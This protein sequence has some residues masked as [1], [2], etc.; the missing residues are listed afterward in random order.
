MKRTLIVLVLFIFSLTSIANADFGTFSIPSP[1]GAMYLGDGYNSLQDN[2]VYDNNCLEFPNGAIETTDGV[3][4]MSYYC[5]VNSKK[6]LEDNFKNNFSGS[7]D[8]TLPTFTAK[9]SL[10]KEIVNETK[11]ISDKITIIAFWRQEDKKVYSNGLPQIK[12]DVIDL[13]QSNPL[14]F[15]KLYGDK[16]VSGVTL[17][18]MFYIVY[19]AD[20]SNVAT[21][22]KSTVK[23]A[24]ELSF[25]KILGANL[26]SSQESFVSEKLSNVTIISR[27][28]AYGINNLTGVYSPSDF[29]NLVSRVSGSQSAVITKELKDFSYTTNYP[30]YSENFSEY[31]NMAREW[32]K[33]YHLL[34]Y[35]QTNPRISS[36]LR[37]DCNLSMIDI[38][39][40]LTHI[41]SQDETS[42]YPIGELSV[43][44][45][46]YNR[47]LTEMNI[48]QRW[49]NMPEV[50]MINNNVNIISKDF[51]FSSIGDIEVL[52]IQADCVC[53]LPFRLKISLYINKD[54]NLADFCETVVTNTS[55]VNLYEGVKFHDKF[56]IRYN[57][58]I[59][60]ND[61]GV[62]PPILIIK[63]S[64]KER[65]TDLIWL[66]VNGY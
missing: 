19:Q 37:T 60:V 53:K 28:Y 39:N 5:F 9:S 65:I 54:G 23:R 6:E 66:H 16:Y 35:I 36:G 57:S 34:E 63:C 58:N 33:H 20:T 27:T 25:N 45:Y 17:G 4:S 47:Y 21:S 26:S 7:G 24:V 64:Y 44:N 8:L 55:I 10:T 22:S 41:Y 38:T 56:T 42:R 61:F 46:L 62:T 2:Y 3:S 14:Q 13:L 52:K 40:Q 29:N 50:I 32:E 15:F 59:P 49:Y 30:G 48:V 31:L 11:F 43:F 12:T 18:K 1:D 51:D